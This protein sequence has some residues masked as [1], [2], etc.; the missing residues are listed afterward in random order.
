VDVAAGGRASLLSRR[1]VRV[2]GLIAER[3]ACL[4]VQAM[5]LLEPGDRRNPGLS[6]RQHADGSRTGTV[7]PASGVK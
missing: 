7:A 3:R 5:K 2:S 1:P 6:E 4:P